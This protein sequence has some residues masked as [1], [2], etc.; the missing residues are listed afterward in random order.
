LGGDPN[1]QL[2]TICDCDHQAL[3][4]DMNQFLD[5]VVDPVTGKTMR[6]K[7]GNP[8]LNIRTNFTGALCL[9][10]SALFYK[11]PGSKYFQAAEDFFLQHPQLK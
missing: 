2:T 3:H 11:G 5:N 9:S 7:R 8:G 6:R 4:K 1:Q 10:T